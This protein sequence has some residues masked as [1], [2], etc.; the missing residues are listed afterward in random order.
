MVYISAREM[1][2]EIESEEE[3]SKLGDEKIALGHGLIEALD[4]LNHID[5]VEKLKRKIV[6]EI[7]SLQKV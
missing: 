6:S 1:A 2:N 3:L 4:N 7:S 5:G